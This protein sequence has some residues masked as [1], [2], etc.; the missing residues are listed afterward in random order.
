MNLVGQHQITGHEVSLQNLYF[1]SDKCK[2][3]CAFKLRA[4]SPDACVQP[5]NFVFLLRLCLYQDP[6][7]IKLCEETR[8]EGKIE[9]NH[10]LFGLAKT[11]CSL[12]AIRVVWMWHWLL[13]ISSPLVWKCENA[14]YVTGYHCSSPLPCRTALQYDLLWFTMSA[15]AY[16]ADQGTSAFRVQSF[17]L[18]LEAQSS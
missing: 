2:N 14:C 3:V 11:S 8:Q 5:K 6:C 18:T 16:W 7:Y 15:A 10:Q 9:Q 12:S 17:I 1:T 4:L 13:F